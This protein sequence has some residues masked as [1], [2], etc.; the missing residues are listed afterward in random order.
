MHKVLLSIG[1]NTEARFNLNRAIHLLK[2]DFP[3]INFTSIIESKPYGSQYKRPFLNT[4]AYFHTTMNKE[5]LISIL[6]KNEINMGRK[7]KDK[8]NGKIVIDIDLIKWNNELIKPE[9]FKRSYVRKLLLE[10]VWMR[11]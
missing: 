2:R 7:P 4:L 1:T 5:D 11:G 6:K 10:V 8:S 3:S 9:D